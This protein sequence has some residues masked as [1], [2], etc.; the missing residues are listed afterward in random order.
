MEKSTLFGGQEYFKKYTSPSGGKNY[1]R[2]KKELR[3]LAVKYFYFAVY[4]KGKGIL[5][6]KGDN[7][8][9][10]VEDCVHPE[11]IYGQVGRIQPGLVAAWW[12]MA[13]RIGQLS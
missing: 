6:Y 2:L 1:F 9:D 10:D 7:G 8:Q 11:G 3:I 4:S 12:V 5:T 13:T